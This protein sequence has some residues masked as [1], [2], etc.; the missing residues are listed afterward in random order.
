MDVVNNHK[1]N[2]YHGPT[3]EYSLDQN[4]D[5]HIE[6]CVSTVDFNYFNDDLS[7]IEK[8]RTVKPYETLDG[9]IIL[10]TKLSAHY[11]VTSD[12]L[13][14]KHTGNHYHYK[15]IITGEM[16]SGRIRKGRMNYEAP[17]YF[18]IDDKLVIDYYGQNVGFDDVLSYITSEELEKLE[19]D[20]IAE[21]DLINIL[22]RLNQ[23]Y[24]ETEDLA[25]RKVLRY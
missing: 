7:I 23:E 18:E 11:I 24:A 13:G 19:F 17:I 15:D 3:N 16:Y 10:V 2:S 5:N 12:F 4:D 6:K 20:R 25:P 21:E 8:L 14:E 1:K 9:K 22:D